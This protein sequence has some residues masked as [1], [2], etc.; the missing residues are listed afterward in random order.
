MKRVLLTCISAIMAFPLLAQSYPGFYRI[1]NKGEAGR[2]ISIQNTKVSDEAKN[3]DYSSGVSVNTAVEAL[4]LIKAKDKDSDAGTILYITGNN[5][6]LTLEA[7]GMNTQTLLNNLGKGDLSLLKGSKGELYTYFSGYAIYLLDYGFSYPAT[8]TSTCGVATSSWTTK[9]LASDEKNYV[10]WT[11]KKID[12]VNEFFGVKPTEGIQIGDKY[13]TTLYTTFA[14]QLPESMK[15]FYIDQ[16]EYYGTPIAE[17]KEITDRKVPAS[18][19]V[20]I[21]CSS[22]DVSENKVV[23]LE[24][25]LSPINGNKLKGNV[26][27]YIPQGN[28][29]AK[30]KN[31]LEY[32]KSTMRVL[33]SVNGKLAFVADNDKALKISKGVKYIPANKAY[34]PINAAYNTKTA[35]GIELLLPEEYEAVIAGINNITVDEKDN[36][37]AGIYTL[38]GVKVKEDNNTEGLKRGIYIIDGKKQVIQ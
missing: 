20:I 8:M 30:L 24:E 1:Q 5:N 9:E 19:P 36:T 14:Y 15:A 6:G 28:E 17:L 35:N 7:Q 33:S 26:F 29:D 27:C 2:Y 10:L 37:D 16:Y 38:T 32:K 18:T 11:F 13:Y 31:A 12:N 23:L 21:E 4:Q 34:L 25:K 3:I 22:N